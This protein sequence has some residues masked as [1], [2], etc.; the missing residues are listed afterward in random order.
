M[1]DCNRERSGANAGVELS[2]AQQRMWIAE[3]LQPGG[4]AYH[5]PSAWRAAGELRVEALRRAFQTV[6]RRHSAL[7]TVIRPAE[8]TPWA[9]VLDEPPA[10]VEADWTALSPAEVQ[11][12]VERQSW[13]PFDLAGEA[14]ARCLLARLAGGDHLLLFL[15]HHIAFDG[16]S[17]SIFNCELSEAYAAACRGEEPELEP[18]ALQ[19]SEYAAGQRQSLTPEVIA[20]MAQPW[21]KRLAGAPRLRLSTRQGTGAGKEST[22]GELLFTMS[23]AAAEAVTAFARTHRT[24]PFA[25]HL[26]AVQALLARYSGQA[27]FC[28]GVP[29]A[30]REPEVEGLIGF[31]VNT[32]AFRARL[33]D[34]PTFRQAVGRT[35]SDT[36]DALSE[37]RLPFEQ[38]VERM[39]PDRTLGEN[40]L[41]GVL[42]AYQNFPSTPL[43]L[44]GVSLEQIEVLSPASV[45]ELSLSLTP[46]PG[47]LLG[48]IRYSA[49]LF[50]RPWVERFAGH[51]SR[52]VETWL[53]APDLPLSKVEFI[54]GQEKERLL[55]L[56]RGHC[57]DYPKLPIHRIF[58]EQAAR[59]P[60]AIALRSGQ[61]TETYADLN[62]RANQLA[63]QLV[64]AGIAPGSVVGVLMDRCMEMVVCWLAVLKAGCAYLPLE[65]ADP[66]ARLA[67]QLADCGVG[68]LIAHQPVPG[69]VR[70]AAAC[71]IFPTGGRSG[72]DTQNLSIEPSIGQAAC[73]MFSSGSTGKPKG[74]AIPHRAILRLLFDNG[75][76]EFSSGD[77]FLFMA[78]PAFD[79]S[80][81]EVWGPLLHGGTC[82]VLSPGRVSLPAVSAAVRNNGVTAMW[83]TS[84]LF[85]ALID[86]TPEALR[87]VRLIMT[88]GEAL[89]AG[90]V[91]KALRLLPDTRLMNGYG[92]T[93]NTT[94]T[95]CWQIPRDFPE[96][97]SGVP[98]GTPIANTRVYVLDAARQLVPE[99]VAGELYASGDGVALGYLGLAEMT[100]ERFLADPF[101]PGTLMYRTGDIVRWNGSG[102]LEFVGRVDDQV[103]I[104]G[105]RIEPG[106]VE[107]ALAGHPAVS[108]AAVIV[109]TDRRGEKAL[110]AYYT[111][112]PG[113]SAGTGELREFL[114]LRLPEFMQPAGLVALGSFP[115][116]PSGKI[117]RAALPEP[118][119]ARAPGDAPRQ[120]REAEIAAVWKRVLGM[121]NIVRTDNFFDLGGHSLAALR[122][123]SAIE[124]ELKLRVTLADL[125]SAPV[126]ADLAARLD[127]N[128]TDQRTLV[129]VRSEGSLTPIL[130]LSA[131]PRFRQLAARLGDQRPVHWLPA[132]DATLL[133]HP[134]RCEDIAAWYVRL[135][136]GQRPSGPWILSGWCLAGTLAFEIARQLEPHGRGA[137]LL[138]DAPGPNQ[139]AGVSQLQSLGNLLARLAYHGHAMMRGERGP[140][141]P[142]VLERIRTIRE[143]REL[144]QFARTY[145]Q[146]L[147]SGGAQPESV[148]EQLL[149]N[150]AALRYTP[151]SPLGWPV[152]LVH[153]RDRHGLPQSKPD[154]GWAPHAPRLIVEWADGDHGTMFEE[155]F[156]TSLAK[157]VRTWLDGLPD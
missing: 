21:I 104:R 102:T 152:L 28:I 53:S 42:F 155:P 81:L 26:A 56:G 111:L 95:T 60:E 153:A 27:D 55:A 32:L 114:R 71:C 131:G 80:T 68:A 4:A 63:R 89:S 20:Q 74:A 2:F 87:P 138:L 118:E 40:P 66:A 62:A 82:A 76:A 19:Y 17:W 88:G 1:S 129:P 51:Y 46:S 39:Q 31:F 41:F 134:C 67:G 156:L 73:I 79:A 13:R 12:A 78:P 142:Y 144:L 45:V 72:E 65:P 145:E 98:I 43:S 148:D 108:Q 137:V 132:I 6:C 36:L 115:L 110:V 34:D 50:D 116:L 49:A 154:A 8:G 77:T 52:L 33:E 38:L 25:V 15:F 117:D 141:I 128:S 64:D 93:E 14:P 143:R 90:H 121:Q 10:V 47:G 124:R 105:H 91:A 100:A 107:A 119:Q 140:L 35:A 23:A 44:C 130:T 106:E 5:I 125:F 59:R 133:P 147:R 112:R 83:I 61:I 75:F 11:Q 84:S 150:Y 70:A 30:N 136:M 58:E 48:T 37:G 122:V 3:Q 127:C 103:K 139:R 24:T 146:S 16:W 120:G 96:T 9:Q 94:F 101:H 86:E 29:F 123:V 97:A 54:S 69:A 99:G 126:L 92:P 157:V 113:G 18:L 135:L 57:G 22:D 7:R 151:P 149:S 109:R 85:N